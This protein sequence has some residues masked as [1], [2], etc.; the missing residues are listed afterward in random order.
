M[1]MKQRRAR[2]GM[3][4]RRV[5]NLTLLQIMAAVLA[6]LLLVKGKLPFLR[7]VVGHPKRLMRWPRLK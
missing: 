6:Q 3:K 5:A 7:A 1:T 4:Q 2:P